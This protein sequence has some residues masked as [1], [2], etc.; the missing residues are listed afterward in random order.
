M[1]I[2]TYKMEKKKKRKERGIRIQVIKHCSKT[3]L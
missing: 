2:Y 1:N 3:Y